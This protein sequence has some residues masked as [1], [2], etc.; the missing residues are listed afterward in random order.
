MALYLKS[1]ADIDA[2]IAGSTYASIDLAT[3]DKIADHFELMPPAAWEAALDIIVASLPSDQAAFAQALF[4]D[5]PP[6]G[7]SGSTPPVAPAD[8]GTDFVADIPA[9]R[10]LDS[11]SLAL[12]T[13]RGANKDSGVIGIWRLRTGTDAD[14]PPGI[15]RGH[16]FDVTDNPRVWQERL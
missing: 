6:D 3:K 16:D 7:G 10:A 15:L 14:A 13:V 12:G 4:Q 11:A 5:T 9:I 2:L 8:G 1:Q